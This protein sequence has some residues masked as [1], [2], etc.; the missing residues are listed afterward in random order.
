[1]YLGTEE[2]SLS[3]AWCNPKC[4][5]ST[6]NQILF[7]RKIDRNAEKNGEDFKIELNLFPGN[8]PISC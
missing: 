2:G 4:A 5:E 3:K 8:Y 1:M 6:G 7:T